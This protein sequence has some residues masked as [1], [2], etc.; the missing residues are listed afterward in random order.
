MKK[1]AFTLIELL[2]VIAI[3]AILAA[4]LFPVFAQAKLAAKTTA[5]LS[6][7]KQLGTGNQLYYNDNDDNRMGR[8][9]IDSSVCE[10]WKQASE[11]YRKSPDLYRDPVNPAA[12]Y[13]DGFSDPVIRAANLCTGAAAPAAPLGSLKQYARGYYWANIFGSRGGGGY[14]DNAGL[15]LS[16]VAASAEVADVYEG[17]GEFTDYGPFQGWDQNVDAETSWLGSAAPTT[18]L[19]WVNTNGKYGEKA[20]NVVYLDSH[21][22]RTGYSSMCGW[23]NEAGQVASDPTKE[24]I[25]NFSINDINALGSGYSWMVGS[26][27]QYCSNMPQQF[28]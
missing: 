22:K 18:G 9:T 12:H 26:V 27:E 5:S 19:Q 10:S 7:M 16:S 2:V 1:R 15:N 14:W 13:L 21:A 23:Y 24:T 11:A 6:N 4:I 28:K 25:W 8:Q 3:I 17:K 20:Q